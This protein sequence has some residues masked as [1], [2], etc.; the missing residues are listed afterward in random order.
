[1]HKRVITGCAF[2]LFLTFAP[3]RGDDGAASIAA[4][5][6]VMKRESRITMAKEVLKISESKVIVDYDFR[7]DSDQD[8]T[9]EVAFP[10]PTYRL[11][12]DEH[13]MRAV[14][15]DDF[16][17]FVE[18]EQVSFSTQ[19]KA[20][21]GHKD[22]TAQ[23]A[24]LHIDI[25]TFGHF[26]ERT[27]SAADIGRL[28]ASERKALIESGLLYPEDTRDEGKWAVQKKYYWLQTFP[29]HA[30]VHIRHQYTPVLGKSNSIA[31]PLVDTGRASKDDDELAS[32]CPTRDLLSALRDDTK[33]PGHRVG[34]QYV[35][36]I[37]TTA[38]TWKTPIQD[39]TLTVERPARA[40]DPNHPATPI[41]FVSFCW[42]GPVEKLDPN[43]FQ[44]HV[45][46][47]VPK[48]E[49]RVGFLDGYLMS[50]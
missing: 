46:G 35:D 7:N 39:F 15:F 28:S 18:G 41:N 14:G 47:F 12:W 36:F 31:G 40:K 11:D 23:L 26:N 29:A 44:A 49:L 33:K 37:L 48:K 42:N 10:I 13:S 9:T 24:K 30:T 2:A 4:G 17:L 19:A 21:L 34:I 45:T 3:V 6:I 25:A 8:I 50:E 22:V 1:M 27:G 38:N 43:H 5:G 20:V 32:V 16:T